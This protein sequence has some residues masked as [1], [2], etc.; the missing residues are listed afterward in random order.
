LLIYVFFV[1]TLLLGVAA[2]YIDMGY[3]RLTQ[4]LMQNAA[5]TAALEGLRKR[6]AP[7]D[8]TDCDPDRDKNRRCAAINMVG[9]AFDDQSPVSGDRRLLSA[10][11]VV[12]FTDSGQGD[13]N[14]SQPY[15]VDDPPVVYNP[16]LLMQGNDAENLCNG[17]LVS[18]TYQG[19]SPSEDSA[20]TRT[21]FLR[22]GATSLTDC[23]TPPAAGASGQASSFLVRLRRTN[24]FQNLDNQAGVSS[25]GPTLPL[26]F[27][28]GTVI[29][30]EDT[31]DPN[32]NHY[33]PR[34]HG[35]TVRAAAIA[36]ARPA[37]QV[38]TP[39]AG[40]PGVTPFVVTH[41]F[42]VSLGAMPQLVTVDAMGLLRQGIG[43]VGQYGVDP[44][45]VGLPRPWPTTTAATPAAGYV[46][47]YETLDVDRVIGFG[48]VDIT[49]STPAFTI[50][51]SGLQLAPANATALVPGGFPVG[52][53]PTAVLAANK[54][55]AQEPTGALLAPALVR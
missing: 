11:P 40:L 14:A 37:L 32:P 22:A 38:G 43:I 5:D 10:G 44:H 12:H 39:A 35:I 24:D 6:D 28:R 17:D 42:W 26:M 47:I 3:V 13:F 9:L 4:S 25:H 51:R 29:E 41:A 53:D 54:V 15:V 55:L 18:G 30:P 50:A 36:D 31:L 16:K 27:G 49:G 19:G 23:S 8:P 7:P 46:P 52:S 48:L 2:L 21:D 34:V 45:V 33:S 20:Y 1:I